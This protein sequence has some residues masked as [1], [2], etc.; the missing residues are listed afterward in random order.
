MGFQIKRTKKSV[1]SIFWI[2]LLFILIF[3]SYSMKWCMTYFGNI[4]MN[5]IVFTLNM[6]LKGT[7]EEY[8]DTYFNEVFNPF[9]IWCM[10]LGFI[11]WNLNIFISNFR[12][13]L[14]IK[15]FRYQNRLD[16]NNIISCEFPKWLLIAVWLVGIIYEAEDNYQIFNYIN[17]NIKASSFIENEYVDANKI[18]IVFPEKKKNLICIFIESAE[19]TF[20]DKKNGGVFDENIIPEMTNIAKNNIS[21]SQS[22]LLKGASVAPGTGWT[23]AG[24]VAQT[25]GMPLKLYAYG[26]GDEGPDNKLG[27]YEY[28]LPGVVSIGEILERIG[29]DNFFMAGSD[30]TFGGRTEYFTQHGNYEIWDYYS[31]LS[32]KKIPEDYRVKWGFEDQKLYEY[33]KEK[34]IKL[35]DEGR[36][37]N[38]SM[39]TVDTHT[40]GGYVCDLCPDKYVES[41][42]NV[43]ACAS[44][45]LEN[46][47][48]WLEQQ[49]FYDDTVIYIAGDHS[50]MQGNFVE[51]YIYDKHHGDT[52]RNVYNVFINS[53]VKPVKMKNREFTTLDFC[54]SILAA[55]G[56]EIEG[57]RIGLGTNLFSEEQTLAEKYGYEEFF[58][59][60]GRKSLFYNK[61]ILYPST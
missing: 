30:F 8:F 26:A 56:A 17:N 35:S 39:L 33:A 20:Q 2:I 32:E 5:E 21:F 25:S 59:E 43:W 49:E 38:F 47:L 10:I 44:C 6:P 57:N 9:L 31:A 14:N 61:E 27:N 41:Y 45:Q 3:L 48:R 40:G 28:F 52:E 36:P 11:F 12:V 53:S 46:F 37:F 50:S 4:S 29:Y 54:P 16:F 55:L 22:E 23:I 34:L 42:A 13:N 58:R 7:S 60:L 1:F 18:D 24:L 15:L 51:E 19:T